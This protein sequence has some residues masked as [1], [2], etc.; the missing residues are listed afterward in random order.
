MILAHNT[1][2]HIYTHTETRLHACNTFT[3]MHTRTHLNLCLAHLI[4]VGV[5]DA[6]V[7]VLEFLAVDDNHFHC[8]DEFAV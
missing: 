8:A 6:L 3:C 4:D 7:H 2:E 1:H 5:G